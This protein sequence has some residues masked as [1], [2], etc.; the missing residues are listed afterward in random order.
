MPRFMAKKEPK[1]RC[2][3]KLFCLFPFFAF[4]QLEKLSLRNIT[5]IKKTSRRHV[6]NAQKNPA[7]MGGVSL[8]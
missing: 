5:I 2:Y 1:N 4:I 3:I 8:A 6:A 7:L